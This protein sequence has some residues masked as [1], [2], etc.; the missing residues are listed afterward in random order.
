MLKVNRLAKDNAA[1]RIVAGS[2]PKAAEA[3]AILDKY[4][5]DINSADDKGRTVRWNHLIFV[6]GRAMKVY[7]LDFDVNSYKSIRLCDNVD[8]DFYQMFDGR[9]LK[10]VWKNSKV[11]V[12][13]EDKGL[14]FGDAFGFNIPVLNKKAL[15]VL[16]PLIKN[17]VELLPLSLNDD[18]LHGINV[19]TVLDAIDYDLSEYLTFMDGKRIMY[20]K[21]FFFKV[22][23]IKNYNIFKIK[24]LRRGYVFVSDSFYQSVIDNN[25]RG[26]KL[27]Q[28]FEYED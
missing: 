20:F 25:L 15:N 17:D 11:E 7:M 24:D 23:K 2:F 18:L 10:D 9:S 14:L 4:G 28:V 6:E 27:E 16:Y 1:H 12:Y 21:K 26:F 22:D 5:I 8:A 19:T 3:R 13:E